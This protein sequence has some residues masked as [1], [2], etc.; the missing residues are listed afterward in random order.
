MSFGLT[1]CDS[2]GSDGTSSETGDSGSEGESTGE[3]M[4]MPTGAMCDASSTLTYESFGE[5][6]M[7]DYCTSCHESTAVGDD[8]F[9]APEDV[10]FD[11]VEDVRMHLM[12]IDSWAGAS[13][14][15]TNTLMPPP[16][17]I[18]IMQPT[19]QERMDLAVWLACGAP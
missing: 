5:K 16:E 8:R 7:N 2:G 18:G 3:P 1:A 15:V 9:D 11:T 13:D 6:F 4:D 17:A 10:N 14:S 12:S 19:L